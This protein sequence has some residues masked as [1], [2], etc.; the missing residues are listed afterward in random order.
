MQGC[1]AGVQFLRLDLEPVARFAVPSNDRGTVGVEQLV[2]QERSIRTG[3]AMRIEIDCASEHIGPFA[4]DSSHESAP[5]SI[6]VK[7]RCAFGRDRI[8]TDSKAASACSRHQ[9]TACALSEG[10]LHDG[11][12]SRQHGRPV[13]IGGSEIDQPIDRPTR[14]VADCDLRDIAPAFAQQPCECGADPARISHQHETM[15]AQPVQRRGCVRCVDLLRDDAPTT[16]RRPGSNRGRLGVCVGARRAGLWCRCRPPLDDPSDDLLKRLTVGEFLKSR[17]VQARARSGQSQPL[18]Q[19]SEDL[20]ALDRVDA[21]IRF[22]IQVAIEHVGWISG[23][24]AHHRDHS[25]ENFVGT[26][27]VGRR[28]R[29]RLQRAAAVRA[30]SGPGDDCLHGLARGQLCEGLL[31]KTRTALGES[32]PF[33]QFTKDLGA[34]D[35]IDAQIRFQVQIG[36]EHLRRIAGAFAD[37]RDH[38]GEHVDDG[39]APGRVRNDVRSGVRN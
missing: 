15:I 14:I 37:D 13:R 39:T 30:G 6:G 22:E 20:G 12:R 11:E 17:F 28:R 35:R 26:S 38:G 34:L 3:I 23:A 27:C 19:L 5:A 7:R 32:Q 4:R 16:E 2:E 25:G 10:G 8:G 18:R 33:G 1:A 29:Q 36:I 31:V 9:Q 24:L 21:Q